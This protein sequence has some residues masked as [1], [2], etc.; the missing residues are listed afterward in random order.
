MTVVRA[1]VEPISQDIALILGQELSPKART[2][3]IAAFAK[4]RLSEAEAI[5][6]AA[7]GHTP[8]HQTFVDGR[9]NAPVETV[10]PDGTVVYVF[11]LI[12]DTLAWIGDQLVRHSPVEHGV[13]ARSHLLF[14]DGQEVDPATPT[15]DAREFVFINSVPYARKVEKGL[16]PQAP[17]GVYEAVAALAS[18]RF[19]NI[20]RIRFS[21]RSFPGGAVGDWAGSTKMRG[22]RDWLTRQPAIT[23]TV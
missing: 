13:Y 7:L 5:N 15:P 6:T 19:G 21:Y 14:A 2:A 10:R 11:D 8:S 12:E 22:K 20:A 3:Q 4:E 23:V 18:R 16:S 1:R 9:H 17:D